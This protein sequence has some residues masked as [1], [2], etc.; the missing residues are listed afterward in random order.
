M[1]SDEK[2]QGRKGGKFLYRS[3]SE[4]GSL[5]LEAAFVLPLLLLF[6][7]GAAY[8]LRAREAQ[9]LWQQAGRN[10]AEE[11]EFAVTILG[12]ADLSK[13]QGSLFGKVPSVLQKPLRDVLARALSQELLFAEQKKEFEK[14]CA[15]RGYL[16]HILRPRRARLEGSFED[17]YL[18]YRSGYDLNFPFFRTEGKECLCIALWNLK[19]LGLIDSPGR[20]EEKKGDNIWKDSNF[21]RGAHF[22]A[23]YGGNLPAT[24]ATISGWDGSEARLINSLDLTAPTYRSSFLLQETIRSDLRKLASYRGTGGKT[25]LGVRIDE[26]RIAARRYILIVPENGSRE[27][28]RVLQKMQAE[29]LALGVQMQVERD[30]ASYRYRKE[31]AEEATSAGGAGG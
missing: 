18:L 4:S 16:T 1:R 2:G 28:D 15:G 26:G 11:S 8:L 19:D 21:R 27:Q 14:A 17:H 25:E 6:F 12:L 7:I 5:S 30:Q 20:G 3:V 29:A 22:R 13:A 24:F 9:L 31:G 23:K 10:T